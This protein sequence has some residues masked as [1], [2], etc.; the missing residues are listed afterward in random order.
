MLRMD[1]EDR[2]VAAKRFLCHVQQEQVQPVI[3][4]AIGCVTVSDEKVE[5]VTEADSEF[6]VI[7][8]PV[9]GGGGSPD[10]GGARPVVCPGKV[11]QERGRRADKATCLAGAVARRVQAVAMLVIV[12]RP[13][14]AA[15]DGI[16]AWEAD[17]S[18]RC[19]M[20]WHRV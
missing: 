8:I 7:V 19:S 15:V 12:G 13:D 17:D 2:Y 5:T 14:G 1:A 4:G 16:W 11:V 20:A 6:T 18:T 3:G 9:V 10:L